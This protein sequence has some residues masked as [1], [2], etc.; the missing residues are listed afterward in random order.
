MPIEVREIGSRKDLR[1]FIHLPAKIHRGHAEWVPPIYA[2]EW[3]YFNPKK[4]RSFEYCDTVRVLAIQD[5]QVT[6]RVMG[7]VNH[8]HNAAQ[9]IRN[10]RFCYLECPD[11]QE[12]A[13]ALLSYIEKWAMNRGMEKLV[14]PYGFSDQ[15]PEGFIIEGQE[16]PAT[17][18]CYYNDDYLVDLVENEG[19]T[20]EVDYVVYQVPV[21]EEI[22]G[23]YR[24][25]YERSLRS[26]EFRIREFTRRRQIKPYIHS[27]FKL[28]NETYSHLYGF[29]PL[30]PKEM[31]DLTRRYLPVLDPRFIKIVLRDEEVVAFALGIPNMIPGIRKSRGRL[32][33]FGLFYI[34]RAGR[35]TSQLDM[36]LGAVKEKFR[37][38]GLDVM[39]GLKI[40][41]SAYRAGMNV[42]DSHHE[43]ETNTNMRAENERMG[44]KIIKRYRVFQKPVI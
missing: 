26:G 22:P 27:V 24:R 2:D 36:L 25:I 4:N 34:L 15:D 33:P 7:I 35:K 40:L 8:R 37:G 21:P 23:F 9:G 5:G 19:Y 18:A 12:T 16:Y 38:R 41:E 29:V 10:G 17:I 42:I 6:G 31:D 13:H 3:S 32:L 1:D 39:M 28:M 43:L 14:G 44:G 20:K 11:D 30:E